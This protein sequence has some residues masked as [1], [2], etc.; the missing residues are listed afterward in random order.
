MLQ[1]GGRKEMGGNGRDDWG[2][3]HSFRRVLFPQR[4]GG[5]MWAPKKE[6]NLVLFYTQFPFTPRLVS[7][8]MLH[9]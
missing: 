7:V 2:D 4:V 1:W 5:Y 9:F 8:V 6:I 3:S